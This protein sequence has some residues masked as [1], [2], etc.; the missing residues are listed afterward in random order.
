MRTL[1]KSTILS[2]AF[3]MSS[4][5]AASAAVKDYHASAPHPASWYYN[6][7]TTASAPCPEGSAGNGPEVCKRIVHPSVPLR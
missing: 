7:Y 3:L 6:P 1:G 2:A 5:I 4:G